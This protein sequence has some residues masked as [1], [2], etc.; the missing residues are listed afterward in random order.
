M[1]A[2]WENTAGTAQIFIDG[3]LKITKTGILTSGV[4]KSGG[5]L[6]LGLDQDLVGGGFDIDQSFVGELAHVYLWNTALTADI[7]TNMTRVCRE[8][9]HPGHVVGW[10][11]FG[12]NL[13]GGV[14]RR[15]FS[16][17]HYEP[18]L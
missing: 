18:L 7:I 15:N 5:K 14:T 11:S 4:I 6:V 2:T 10:S 16:R 9:P 8:F 12:A 17:C 1:C 13:N 3:N